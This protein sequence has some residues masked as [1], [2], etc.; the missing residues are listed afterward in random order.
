MVAAFRFAA[1]FL[2]SA[3]GVNVEVNSVAGVNIESTSAGSAQLIR[4]TPGQVL[5]G[6]SFPGPSKS[7]D[8]IVATAKYLQNSFWTVKAVASLLSL[9]DDNLTLLSLNDDNLTRSSAS[10]STTRGRCRDYTC[11]DGMWYTKMDNVEDDWC[12]ADT[13]DLWDVGRCCRK[14]S[15]FERDAETIVSYIICTPLMTFFFA[16]LYKAMKTTPEVQEDTEADLT[17]WSSRKFACG[18]D[19]NAFCCAF[20]CPGLRWA[21]SLAMVGL[22]SYWPAV[23][24]MAFLV[25]LEPMFPPLT[26]PVTSVTALACLIGFRLRLKKAFA[27]KEQREDFPTVCEEC[28]FTCFCYP[29]SITQEARHVKKAAMVGSQVLVLSK[30]GSDAPASKA[31]GDAPASKAEGEESKE[32]EKNPEATA[33]EPEAKQEDE[34]AAPKDE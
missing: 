15:L 27:F 9:N 18:E 1:A 30:M 4:S 6:P 24:A 10:S 25:T 19:C 11:P 34:A 22:L 23:A 32:E 5:P 29:C 14:Q 21:D 13:C 17:D 2:I 8:P 28:L 7:T 26:D 3:A 12:H 16:F 31:E 20:W 33:A